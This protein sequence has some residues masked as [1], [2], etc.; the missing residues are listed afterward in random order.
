MEEAANA[1]DVPRGRLPDFFTAFLE[2]FTARHT[3][4]A[5]HHFFSYIFLPGAVKLHD[6]EGCPQ[7]LW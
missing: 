2:L 6:P 4:D 1:E 5:L 3:F 7:W